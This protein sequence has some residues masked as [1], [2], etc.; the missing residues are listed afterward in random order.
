VLH[1][2][3]FVPL[4]P[5]LQQVFIEAGNNKETIKTA[6]KRGYAN[7]LRGKERESN[8]QIYKSEA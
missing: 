6:S 7:N 1:N 4:N 5:H 3:C 2:L 8:M